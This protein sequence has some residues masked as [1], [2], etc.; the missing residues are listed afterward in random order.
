MVSRSERKALNALV[1]VCEEEQERNYASMSK[2]FDDLFAAFYSL[3]NLIVPT[4]IEPTYTGIHLNE[5]YEENDFLKLVEQFRNNQMLHAKYSLQIVHDALKLHKKFPNVA[6]CDL[7]RSSLKSVII[8]GDLHGSFRDLYYIIQKFGIPGKHFRFVFNGDFV[9]R[10]PQQCEVLLTLLYAFLLYPNRVFLNRGNHEDISLNLNQNFRP[11]F[12]NDCIKKFGKYGA[13]FFR[14][15]QELFK[16]LPLATVVNNRAG[17]KC[18]VTHGGISNKTDLDYI[19]S[20]DLKRYEFSSLTMKN[21]GSRSKQKA[22]EQLGDILWSDPIPNTSSS[23][24]LN[25]CFRNSKRGFGSLFGEDISQ[26]FCRK[27]GFS[28]IVRSHEVRSEGWSR[29]QT[30]CFTI[31][32]NS[33]YCQG[34][35]RAA[36]FI[37]NQENKFLE[38][39][40]FKT[41]HFDPGA[42]QKEKEFLLSSFKSYLNREYVY[43]IKKFEKYD[44]KKTGKNSKF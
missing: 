38:Y 24:P 23:M 26:R 1:S 14:Q 13:E 18:F 19:A 42:Y 39:H 2:F 34:T 3:K 33:N 27:Y 22:L 25:G 20:D 4:S 16:Y 7:A 6:V 11:N 10:G 28:T 15:T 30:A 8:V 40:M 21:Y 9:D 17:Y 31:F 12:Q 41:D 32:S 29:D 44:I 36:V 37:L 35:N 5:K 43:L